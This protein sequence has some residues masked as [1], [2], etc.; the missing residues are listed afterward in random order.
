LYYLKIY[1]D[2]LLEIR[3]EKKEEKA[4]E[5]R[6]R[7]VNKRVD[8]NKQSEELSNYETIISNPI[9]TL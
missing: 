7:R 3:E 1:Q 5:S 9:S 4:Y 6:A 2:D 8:K